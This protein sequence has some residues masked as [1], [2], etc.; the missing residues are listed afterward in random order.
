MEKWDLV[1]VYKVDLKY[2]KLINVIDYIY[3]IIVVL[4]L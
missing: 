4:I 1:W 3:I 2:E